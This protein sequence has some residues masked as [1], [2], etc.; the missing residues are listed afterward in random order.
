MDKSHTNTLIN[1]TLA[2][3]AAFFLTTL[4]HELGHFLVYYIGGAHPVLYHNYVSASDEVIGD[5]FRVLAALGGPIISLVQVIVFISILK[6]E[7]KRGTLQ[8]FFLWLGLLGMV[9][10]FGYLMITPIS[11]AGDTGKVADILHLDLFYRIL[12]AASGFIVLLRILLKAGKLFTA[13]IPGKEDIRERRKFVY[14]IMFFPIILGS[15]VKTAFA[16]PVPVW[17]SVLYTATSAWV[18]MIT[19]GVILRNPGRKPGNSEVQERISLPMI[20]LLILMIVLNR[21]LVDGWAIR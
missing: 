13:F 17:I 20:A 15:I 16:F 4:I 8:L 5:I 14:T 11:S 21:L 12:I 2:F 9:N 6:N 10:F 3:T 1:S 19:F 7:S 18:I